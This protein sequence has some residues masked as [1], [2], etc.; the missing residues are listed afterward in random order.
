[1]IPSWFDLGLLCLT[2][3][4]I[5]G[6]NLLKSYLWRILRWGI[7]R[8]FDRPVLPRARKQTLCEIG[9]GALLRGWRE[10]RR[11][12]VRQQPEEPRGS[13]RAGGLSLRSGGK[14]PGTRSILR[15]NQTAPEDWRMWEKELGLPCVGGKRG[16]YAKE[17]ALREGIWNKLLQICSCR[18]EN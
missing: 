11:A 7:Q 6:D 13:V 14:W 5:L 9:L 17:Q 16:Y 3:G 8:R 18:K 2:N 10:K 15:Q 12:G 1:M 4:L